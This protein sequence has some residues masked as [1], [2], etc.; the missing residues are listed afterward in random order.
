M[1]N[2]A[3]EIVNPDKN[4]SNFS[5]KLKTKS[6]HVTSDPQ[7]IADTLNHFFT[8]IGPNIANSITLSSSYSENFLHFPN[9]KNSLFLS[10]SLLMN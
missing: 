8:D 3:C 1:W 9:T 4:K 2:T 7:V 6:G 5:R 10:P